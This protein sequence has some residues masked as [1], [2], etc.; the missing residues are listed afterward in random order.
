MRGA[1]NAPMS[2]PLLFSFRRCPYAIRAR[3][4]LQVAQIEVRIEEVQL[5]AKPASLLAA[6]PKG[7]V[8]VLV[9]ADG[10][11]LEQ[12]LDIMNWALA[13]HDPQRW[14]DPALAEKTA[15]LI[16]LNDGPFKHVLDRY[17]YPERHPTQGQQD[18]RA[19]AEALMLAPLE[20]RLAAHEHLLSER[21]T[22]ADMALLP[23]IRQF[24]AVDAAWFEQ[25]PYP[26]L[27]AWLERL[28]GSA[29]FE[30][31]MRKR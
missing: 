7:T 11:V 19:Q 27:R 2:T 5:R 22:L 17:K 13:Q 14:R 6:S 12:S 18:Y 30:A 4:A 1:D 31:V 26:R 10:Q 3:L 28:T 8:P 29:L 15:A 21:A 25:A 24:A 9:L 16:A 23:F 20:T